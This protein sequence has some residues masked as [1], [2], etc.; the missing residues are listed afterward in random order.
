MT[1]ENPH[2]KMHFLLKWMKWVIFQPVPAMLV[3]R[4]YHPL[5]DFELRLIVSRLLPNFRT[6]R[7]FAFASVKKMI[8]PD[9]MTINVDP[10]F[11]S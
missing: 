10:I 3:F 4:A 2:V 6:H 8:T 5:D 11:S 9:S 1:L 7:N